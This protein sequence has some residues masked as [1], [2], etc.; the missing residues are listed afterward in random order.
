MVAAAPVTATAKSS[1]RL[2]VVMERGRG[3]P[4]LTAR[5]PYVGGYIDILREGARL[6]PTRE[7]DGG[8]FHPHSDVL[9]LAEQRVR[10]RH[11]WTGMRSR[12][13]A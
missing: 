13:A 9:A 1:T 8:N 5:S 2:A 6:R 3:R 7:S 11:A 12:L 10:M 4:L